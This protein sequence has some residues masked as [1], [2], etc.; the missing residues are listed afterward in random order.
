MCTTSSTGIASNLV[1]FGQ[2]GGKNHLA[3]FTS[4]ASGPS[5]DLP[6]P[7]EGN[8]ARLRKA[9][10]PVQP[11][12]QVQEAVGSRTVFRVRLMKRRFVDRHFRPPPS[13]NCAIR[14]ANSAEYSTSR[15]LWNRRDSSKL[16][17]MSSNSIARDRVTC[18]SQIS[19]H[20]P[21]G[22]REAM[23][24]AHRRN[25][26]GRAALNGVMSLIEPVL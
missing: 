9:S 23:R 19:A 15:P 18:R 20:A 5:Q 16:A 12:R 6:H 21:L 24:D 2:F 22:L 26:L 13:T 8:S 11:Q 4:C 1:M 14:F 7:K 3:S 10:T 25:G 17:P